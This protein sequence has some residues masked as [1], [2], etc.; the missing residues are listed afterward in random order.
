MRLA[1]IFKSHDLMTYIS[2]SANFRLWPFSMVKI[3]VIGRF[4]SSADGSKLIFYE[5]VYAPV[6][7]SPSHPP[8]HT[9][10]DVWGISGLMWGAMT[11]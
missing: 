6:I 2:W 8:T 5:I 10:G 1:G 11:F 4:L 3:F 9:Y 7:C